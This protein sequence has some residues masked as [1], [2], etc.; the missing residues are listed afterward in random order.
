[1]A[2]S[3]APFDRILLVEGQDDKH[4]IWQI[5]R[6]AETAFSVDRDGY[7]MIV[8]LRHPG[9]TFLIV[10]KTSLSE[11]LEAIE[12]EIIANG[13]RVVGVIVD[14]DTQPTQRWE[15]LKA[16]F[17]ERIPFP[18][19][20]NPAGVIIPEQPGQPRI[21]VW[22]MP[23]NQSAG[24]LE[25]FARQM[26]PSAAPVWTEAQQYIDNIPPDL[27]KFAPDKTD[28]AKLYAW[29]S[30]RREPSRM[31]AAIGDGDLETTGPL[32]Q[33]FITWLADLFG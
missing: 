25:D 32:C 6:R 12:A 5:C 28:K 14:S 15:Q 30:T 4:V 21:G 24:E 29:L 7:D 1:M 33:T 8:T 20:P 13:R 19:T 23:D 9:T 31:G 11:E 10:E 3:N 27:R 18:N 2:D 22:M 16:A 26:I 17:P